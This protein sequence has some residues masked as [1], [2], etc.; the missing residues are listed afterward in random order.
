M[1]TGHGIGSSPRPTGF[2]WCLSC[3]L[4]KS[5]VPVLWLASWSKYYVCTSDAHLS[6]CYQTQLSARTTTDTLICELVEL[7]ANNNTLRY[8]PL[9]SINSQNRPEH[10]VISCYTDKEWESEN[11]LSYY[12]IR[13][14]VTAYLTD[15]KTCF[16]QI[17]CSVGQIVVLV[18]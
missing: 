8:I 2:T 17:K 16:R 9:W 6:A 7:T 1:L 3:P 12:G 15:L 13:I 11:L 5:H 18:S 10:N 14:N 4:L